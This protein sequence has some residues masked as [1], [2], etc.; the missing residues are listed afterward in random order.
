MGNDAAGDEAKRFARQ[1][2]VFLLLPTID[3]VG[4]SRRS[5]A[6]RDDE[7]AFGQSGSNDFF[8]ELRVR[9]EKKEK[10]G[11]R[12]EVL[13]IVRQKKLSNIFSKRGSAGSAGVDDIAPTFK[14]FF[15]EV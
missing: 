15:E 2:E 11:A 1:H 14:F 12:M 5:E 6:V 3:L 9:G 4:D 13:G 8:N 7:F 10:L